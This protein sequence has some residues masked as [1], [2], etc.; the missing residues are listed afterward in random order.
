M[1]V[2]AARVQVVVAQVVGSICHV[3][4]L[5]FTTAASPLAQHHHLRNPALS[6]TQK[7]QTSLMQTDKA[8]PFPLQAL[9]SKTGDASPSGPQVKV[10][11]SCSP[12]ALIED[13]SGIIEDEEIAEQ[14]DAAGSL[15]SR[16]YLPA[17]FN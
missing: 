11:R 14:Q 2:L 9:A 6:F 5:A 12:P 7:H 3:N 13:T 8:V 15:C 16:S 10:E 1:S 17:R 4:N